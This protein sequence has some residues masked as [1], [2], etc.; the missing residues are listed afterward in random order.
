MADFIDFES[1]RKH[2]EL[3]RH[4]HGKTLGAEPFL[5]HPR[6]RERAILTGDALKNFLFGYDGNWVE[7]SPKSGTINRLSDTNC[8]FV[9]GILNTYTEAEETAQQIANLTGVKITLVY[10]KT[11]GLIEDLIKAKN[12]DNQK[13][14]TQATL[15]IAEF[16]KKD[17]NRNKSVVIMAHS[18]GAA[19]VRMAVEGLRI[20][21]KQGK[22]L[23]V[24]TFGGYALPAE[25]WRTPANVI[26]FVNAA[27][28]VP[29]LKSPIIYPEFPNL[30][31]HGMNA[32]LGW[33]PIFQRL[34][35]KTNKPFTGKITIHSSFI[36]QFLEY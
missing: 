28:P 15:Q 1:D 13:I 8:Y 14:S 26:S 31:K 36:E 23:T 16:L 34:Q 33:I 3:G 19:V 20:T 6:Q 29:K 18:R 2:Y 24:I 9:N 30:S 17:L 11:E 27:D 25:N 32:Y 5:E 4:T 35:A 7:K 12:I 10:S 21:E 22:R